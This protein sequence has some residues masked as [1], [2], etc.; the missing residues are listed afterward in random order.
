[1]R[2][3]TRVPENTGVPRKMSGFDQTAGDVFWFCI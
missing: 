3:G 2:N 1:M